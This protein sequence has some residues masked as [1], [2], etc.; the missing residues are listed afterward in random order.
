[1]FITSA[2]YEITN[3]AASQRSVITLET[4]SACP[5]T[6]LTNW[7]LALHNE[8]LLYLSVL[9]SSLMWDRPC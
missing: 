5:V 3:T 2:I 8:C 4:E 7:Q 9:Y 1:M 6:K